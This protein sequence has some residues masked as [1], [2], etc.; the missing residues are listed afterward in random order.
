[1]I[2]H[3]GGPYEG[4]YALFGY[5]YIYVFKRLMAAVPEAEILYGDYIHHSSF[6]LLK[7]LATRSA[8]EVYY[9]SQQHEYG[10][11]GKGHLEFT[12]L[13]CVYVKGD[14]KRSTGAAKA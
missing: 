13:L 11:N 3:I 6:F 5:I 7:Y 10:S 8:G 4:G 14:S 12:A 2:F 9:K 1:M